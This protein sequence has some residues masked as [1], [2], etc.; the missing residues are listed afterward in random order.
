MAGADA[1]MQLS[2][3]SDLMQLSRRTSVDRE[4][5][6]VSTSEAMDRLKRF[7]QRNSAQFSFETLSR[8]S[9]EPPVDRTA[10]RSVAGRVVGDIPVEMNH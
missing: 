10:T 4:R 5:T 1:M 7:Y 6:G 3:R 8:T 2:R 9:Y